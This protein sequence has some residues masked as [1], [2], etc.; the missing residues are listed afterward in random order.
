MIGRVGL[1]TFCGSGMRLMIR[2]RI[3]GSTFWPPLPPKPK[4][5]EI[6]PMNCSTSS[7]LLMDSN[8]GILSAIEIFGESSLALTRIGKRSCPWISG[9][10]LKSTTTSASRSA[11]F[12]FLK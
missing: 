11:S 1:C 5:T 2:S 3:T 12:A 10:A 6:F 9:V 8:E 4:A 7:S